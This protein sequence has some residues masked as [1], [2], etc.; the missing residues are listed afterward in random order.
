MLG[1][2]PVDGAGVFHL[3]KFA[4]GVLAQQGVIGVAGAIK[5]HQRPLHQHVQSLGCARDRR[6]VHASFTGQ[7]RFRRLPLKGDG[8]DAQVANSC[9]CSAFNRS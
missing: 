5:D 8:K 6:F 9:R 2:Q 1:R 4:V 7:Q 3:P